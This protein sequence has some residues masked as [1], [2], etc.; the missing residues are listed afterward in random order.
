MSQPRISFPNGKCNLRLQGRHLC[1]PNVT[2]LT[3]HS[4]YLKE[5][6]DLGQEL[7]GQKSTKEFLSSLHRTSFILS[8]TEDIGLS[9]DE[10][11]WASQIWQE[12]N[13][14][15][16]EAKINGI[17]NYIR[18]TSSVLLGTSQPN[19][20]EGCCRLVSRQKEQAESQELNWMEKVLCSAV[21]KHWTQSQN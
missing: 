20:C 1:Y 16:R 6:C 2:V 12:T 4:F 15:M 14:A 8:M 5:I 9:S 13:T 17:G 11:Y 19:N 7:V 21:E 10:R 18:R 3:M